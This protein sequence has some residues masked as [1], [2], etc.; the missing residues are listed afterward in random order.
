MTFSIPT[1]T[2]F[3]APLLSFIYGLGV[4]SWQ[5]GVALSI[6]AIAVEALTA[7]LIIENGKTKKY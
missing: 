3:I 6:H 5:A 4:Y 1:W 2:V 7:V